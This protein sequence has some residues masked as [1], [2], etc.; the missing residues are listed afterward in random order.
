M[1]KNRAGW[2]RIY[3]VTM[4]YTGMEEAATNR[5]AIPL[6]LVMTFTIPKALSSLP[7]QGILVRWGNWGPAGTPKVTHWG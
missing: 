5:E 6:L 1:D 2:M 3:F 4:N 7:S